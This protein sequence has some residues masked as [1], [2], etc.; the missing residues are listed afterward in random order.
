MRKLAV[1][2]LLS[3]LVGCTVTSPS[4]SPP[5]PP[6][7]PPPP[8]PQ[9]SW[10]VVPVKVSAFDNK[11]P[12]KVT[13]RVRRRIVT[14]KPLERGIKQQLTRML[15]QSQAFNVIG[16][17]A[18]MD[19]EK[20]GD[21]E[22]EGKNI[23]ALDEAQL[24]IS[25]DLNIYDVSLASVAEGVNEDPLLHGLQEDS[26]A[27]DAFVLLAENADK[28]EQDLI[29]FD[30]RLMDATTSNEIGHTSFQCTAKDWDGTLESW[31]GKQLRASITPP[32][33]P[34][35]Q[36]TQACLIRAVNWV[37]E[38]YDL[39]RKNPA[40]FLN[41]RKIQENLNT[42]GYNCGPIDGIRGP[43]T[44]TCIQ[45]FLAKTGAEEKDLAKKIEEEVGKLPVSPKPTPRVV[46]KPQAPRKKLEKASE[47]DEKP[48][49]PTP[50]E[51]GER[52]TPKP[53]S[54]D[55]YPEFPEF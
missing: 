27:E 52:A 34:M 38:S 16:S 37:G 29:S 47:T 42:L 31:F 20:Q 30:V 5:S 45:A 44:E 1:M 19:D 40:A 32:R 46:P 21:A 15:E 24:E 17:S 50:P 3:A 14:R 2:V 54:L 23:G 25:G 41:Y 11:T 10:G 26:V 6:S 4:P 8:E 22:K 35:Q 36:A 9:W 55:D 39:W 28:I 18:A 53:P 33:T 7:P 12:I 13:Q 48:S 43:R 51:N 49:P